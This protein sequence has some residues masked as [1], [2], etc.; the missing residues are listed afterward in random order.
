MLIGQKQGMVLGA[1]SLLKIIKL[2][3]KSHPFLYQTGLD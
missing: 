2:A 3:V 1:G